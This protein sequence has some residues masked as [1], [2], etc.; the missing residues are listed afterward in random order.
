VIVV[1]F[2][3]SITLWVSSPFEPDK[4]LLL[5]DAYAFCFCAFIFL[6]P[7]RPKY[8]WLEKN[9]VSFKKSLSGKWLTSVDG[10]HFYYADDQWFVVAVLG[11]ASILCASLID[12]S[13]PP[14]VRVRAYN[15]RSTTLY[16]FA[17]TDGGSITAQLDRAIEPFR[18]WVEAHGGRIEP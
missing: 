6:A 18:Q 4:S 11:S 16:R 12:F 10:W 2:I 1:L 8:R 13:I 14:R 3:C 15:L 17:T 7:K 5:F 9:G